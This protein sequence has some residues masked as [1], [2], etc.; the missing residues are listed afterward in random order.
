MSARASSGTTKPVPAAD[1]TWSA[2]PISPRRDSRRKSDIARLEA[3]ADPVE[4][5]AAVA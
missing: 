4:L 3:D 1:R 2:G 5:H